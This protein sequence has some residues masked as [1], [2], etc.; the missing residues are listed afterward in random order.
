MTPPPNQSPFHSRLKT[1]PFIP[2]ALFS[3][4]RSDPG[5]I[6]SC[7]IRIL[8]PILSPHLKIHAYI[9]TSRF[10]NPH[11]VHHFQVIVQYLDPFPSGHH[12]TLTPTRARFFQLIQQ[13]IHYAMISSAIPSRLSSTSS[14]RSRP[15]RPLKPNRSVVRVLGFK[16]LDKKGLAKKISNPEALLEDVTEK[17]EFYCGADRAE[18]SP[19]FLYDGVAWSVREQLLDR[20]QRT[21]EMWR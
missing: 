14:L 3:H 16:A 17:A 21:H 5:P 1:L 2:R 6:D 7:K 9:L 20:M 18:V 4:P 12:Y 19:Q 8:K 11:N 13:L 10:N 15:C